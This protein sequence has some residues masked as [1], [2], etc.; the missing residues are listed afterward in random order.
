MRDFKNYIKEYKKLP[1]EQIQIQFRRK[2]LLYFLNKYK[3]LKV[4]EVGCGFLPLFIDYENYNSF[5]IIE[6]IYEFYINA[7]NK[8]N[9]N[10]RIN[11]INKTLE[12]SIDNSKSTDYDFIIISSLLHEIENPNYF[13]NCLSQLCN[14]N[15][16]IC[17][18]VPN[19]HSLH[20]LLA[21]AMGLIESEYQLS[22]TQRLMQQNSIFDTNKLTD[23]LFNFGYNSFYTETYFIKPFSHKQMQLLVDFKILNTRMLDGLYNLS[24]ILP[25]IGSELIVL[26]KFKKGNE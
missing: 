13:L 1:F 8:A 18:I 11:V 10:N 26:A 6:P 20:R 21:V 15:T 24:S 23:Y 17:F 2:K 3:P 7:F 19:S 4:L 5:T 12:E 25:D 16:I 9:N 14:D 22:S